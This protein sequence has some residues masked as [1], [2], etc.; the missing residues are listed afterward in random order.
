M[1]DNLETKRKKITAQKKVGDKII[2]KKAGRPRAPEKEKYH[3]KMPVLLRKEMQEEAKR[4]GIN[5][6]AFVC[7]AVRE[8]LDKPKLNTT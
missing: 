1:F 5:M 4:I 3:F 6:S 2:K 8:K 7:S